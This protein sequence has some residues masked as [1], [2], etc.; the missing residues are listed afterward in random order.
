MT[1]LMP[2]NCWMMKR[3]TA[4]MSAGRS[5][6]CTSSRKDDDAS[7][8]MPWR[9][10]AISPSTSSGFTFSS[11]LRASSSRP[12]D[13]NQRGLSGRPRMPMSST[14]AGTIPVMSIQRHWP[15]LEKASS[16]TYAT[17]I[18]MVIINWKNDTS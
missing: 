1:V 7:A 17:R 4:T 3:P 10:S 8:S 18:P 11:T 5:T 12:F 15:L 13:M 2:V 16:F 9:M 14:M 6:G